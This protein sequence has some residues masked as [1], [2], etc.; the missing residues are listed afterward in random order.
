MQRLGLKSLLLPTEFLEVMTNPL[1]EIDNSI[2]PWLGRS[3]KMIDYHMADCFTAKGIELTK[4]Q[5]ILL[6][7][8]KREN[9]QAQTNLAFIT[10]RDKASLARLIST[11]ERKGLVK[12]IACKSDKR[13]KH[14]HITDNGIKTL[15]K[16]YPVVQ[17]IIST[18]E[19]G[20]EPSDMETA[21]QV[22]K[23]IL[24]N[25]QTVEAKKELKKN[26]LEKI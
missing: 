22:L 18:I 16:A 12:R 25:I 1:I 11:M 2:L 3:M 4:T 8:L 6:I 24:T 5:F 13:I 20:I 15:E 10:N 26:N 21:T 19:I 9:G 23:K 17:N 7:L 14:V